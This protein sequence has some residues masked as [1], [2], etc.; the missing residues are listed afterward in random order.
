MLLKYRGGNLLTIEPPK[1]IV[2]DLKGGLHPARLFN[3]PPV[4]DAAP[5]SPVV[6]SE[7]PLG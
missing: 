3:F 1:T 5:H 2:P 6:T 7:I 4:S